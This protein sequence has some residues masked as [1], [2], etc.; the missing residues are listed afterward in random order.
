MRE[1]TAFDG[2]RKRADNRVL[3]NE[4]GKRFGAPST[5]EGHAFCYVSAFRLACRGVY[6]QRAR[7]LSIYKEAGG[8]LLL[9]E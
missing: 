7:S 6:C 9:V 4:V 8:T 5:V 3:A 2:T 1:L